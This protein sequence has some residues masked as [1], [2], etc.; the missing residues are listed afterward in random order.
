V[1]AGA[2]VVS[3]L[4]LG[5]LV[6]TLMKRSLPPD[7][8]AVDVERV[9]MRDILARTV[10]GGVARRVAEPAFWWA[11]FLKFIP[12][13]QARSKSAGSGVGVLEKLGAMLDRTVA[14]CISLWTM[15]VWVVAA[16]TAAPPSSYRQS[17]RCW[18]EL[19]REVLS[20][21]GRMGWK[22]WPLRMVW[23]LVEIVFLLLSPVLDRSV[24]SLLGT[25]KGHALMPGS[26]LI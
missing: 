12:V 13:R 20:V 10:L 7:E 8:Y 26:F 1:P 5:A 22:N 19:G 6:D 21:D 2:Y 24:T 25:V 4:W 23:A 18:L 3:P 14:L 17:T 9:M 11:I 15:G 16:Y